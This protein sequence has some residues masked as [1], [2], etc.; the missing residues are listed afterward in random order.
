MPSCFSYLR[1]SAPAVTPFICPCTADQPSWPSATAVS[2]ASAR[3][4][5]GRNG[6][7]SAGGAAGAVASAAAAAAA[8]ASL[9]AG[10]APLTQ[11]DAVG[12]GGEGRQR[13]TSGERNTALEPARSVKNVGESMSESR[14]R[15]AAVPREVRVASALRGTRGE[16]VI[17]GTTRPFECAVR[18]P[19][20]TVPPRR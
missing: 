4:R 5:A 12:D 19:G 11:R 7:C 14:A 1:Q 3:S 17:R 8:A 13:A 18:V 10:G 9:A 16:R 2:G 15:T 20:P 6:V